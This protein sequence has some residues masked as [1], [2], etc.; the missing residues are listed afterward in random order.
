MTGKAA[1]GFRMTADAMRALTDMVRP[2]GMSAFSRKSRWKRRGRSRERLRIY[3][4]AALACAGLVLGV[5]IAVWLDAM[6][7]KPPR[8][9]VA[10]AV[11]AAFP[12]ADRASIETQTAY[13]P[14]HGETPVTITLML[15]DVL[16]GARDG[17]GD[18]FARLGADYGI[19]EQALSGQELGRRIEQV[20]SAVLGSDVSRCH[21]YEIGRRDE[22]EPLRAL[23]IFP[24]AGC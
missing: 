10:E 23:H 18:P 22:Q 6:F 9:P 5:L 7:G 19:Q 2:D 1:T 4:L 16:I 21:T 12:E 3:R 13:L 14:D 8:T 20:V 11:A 17:A 24:N 15:P